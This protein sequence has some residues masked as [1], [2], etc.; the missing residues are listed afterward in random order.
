MSELKQIASDLLASLKE[1]VYWSDRKTDIWDKAHTVIL[2]AESYLLSKTDDSTFTDEKGTVWNVPTAYAYAMA[3]KALANK[4][5][6]IEQQKQRIAELEAQWKRHLDGLPS[7]GSIGMTAVGVKWLAE[8]ESEIER[9]RTALESHPDTVRLNWIEKNSGEITGERIEDDPN[10]DD[11]DTH[12]GWA[13]YGVIEGKGGNTVASAT[14]DTLREAIDNAMRI[15]APVAT[16]SERLKIAESLLSDLILDEINIPVAPKAPDKVQCPICDGLGV[17]VGEC[18]IL[19]PPLCSGCDGTGFI[20]K[21][22]GE[23]L[24]DLTNIIYDLALALKE[25]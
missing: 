14:A 11:S 12:D 5:I 25:K 16:S 18:K 24:K 3:C 23:K 17:V 9:L 6:E 19:P 7:L 20:K 2:K 13:V 21:E 1:V 4:Y 8:H 15:V 10:D 22:V